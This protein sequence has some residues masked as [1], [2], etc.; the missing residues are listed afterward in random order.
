[1][2][3]FNQ[4]KTMA[5]P[6]FMSRQAPPNYVAG[7]GRGATGFTTRSDIGPARESVAGD[8]AAVP[9]V[10]TGAQAPK[11]DDDDERFQDPDNETG[12]FSSAPYEVD[13]E[14]AD[15]IYEAIDRKMDERR[16]ARREAREREEQEKYR[17][18]RPKI[19]Q[20][21]ADLKRGLSTITD[22]QW[23][24]IPE[25]GDLVRKRS[26]NANL[27]V[28]ERYMP[29]PDSVLLGAASS[30]YS[31][32]LSARDQ[33]L[34]GAAT[35]V[36]G[37]LT[38]FVQFGQARDKVLGLKLD[39]VS[40]SVS[41]QTTIDPKGYLT[42][43]NSVQVKSDAEISDIK[44]ARTLLR[45]VTTTNPKHGPGWI[46]AARLEEV[47]G[48]LAVAREIIAKGC[49]EC[50]K[51][52]D[53]WLEA[54][55]LNT[56]DNAKV[57]LANAVRSL[58]QS[59]KIWMRATQL[60]AEIKAKKRVLRR[61]LE[62]IP[63]SVSLWKATV[64]L[65]EDPEDARILL[66]QAVKDVPLAVELWLA[67]AKLET[68]DNARKVLNQ[69]RGQNP[70]SHE[71]WIT[72]AKLEEH[73][74]S[75]SSP[76]MIIGRAVKE[77]QQ[78]GADIDREV[79]IKEA[80]QCEKDASPH[81][82]Q[83][84]IKYTIEQ[85]VEPEDYKITFVEDAESCIAHGSIVTARAIFAHA[86]SLLPKDRSLWQKAAF[87]EKEHG[88]NESLE[89]L[90][91]RAVRYCPDAE[92]LWLMGAKQKWLMGDIDGARAVLQEAFAANPN[93]EQL[94]LAAVKLEAENE[95]Y[96]RARP[97]LAKARNEA[98]TVRVWMKS[99]VFERQLGQPDAAIKLLDEALVKFPSA[100][101]LWMMRGQVEEDENG[102]L[103]AAREFYAKGVKSCSKSIPLWILSSRLEEKAD[104][105]TRARALLE[106]ARLLNP[107]NDLLWAESIRVEQRG[108]NAAMSKALMAKALQEC[109]TSGLLWAEAIMAEPRPT[110]KSKST[111]A[112]KKCE[113]DPRVLVTIARLFWSERKLDK[114]RSWF[115]RAT[116]IDPD[117]G[118][119]WAWWYAFE[120]EQGSEDQRNDVVTKCEAA[121]PRHGELWT[122]FSKDRRNFKL[123]IGEIL[124][125]SGK[126]LKNS[127]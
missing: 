34:G 48:K 119:T 18:E 1:M 55:R 5:V 96:H 25:V 90:L 20:Q 49:E 53:V 77:L 114:A 78:K 74:G 36:D 29:V 19:Q 87:L 8:A 66:S 92:V 84:I 86:T 45:S 110:R 102:N 4:L 75:T 61:A 97:L 117:L 70:T 80:E 73:H 56:V 76:D 51:S 21:F 104:M 17:K 94:Y 57:I 126:S 115:Q 12:L 106:R 91:K 24:N 63:N 99:A 6:D 72:A 15:K 46:A 62:F 108:G 88:T 127:I 125:L 60:E 44:K 93:S 13:D 40:D 43:L 111:D 85:G 101:K 64:S 123:K 105:M 47:A 82:C 118:D 71:I 42:D 103:A 79:W 120:K 116:K 27:K 41:G 3:T 39:Q 7:L 9:G 65:E 32:T 112:L 50:P 83:A 16:R 23:A 113:N 31:N 98:G 69:A 33:V 122:R 58:P 52:E 22:D 2:A 124:V 10:A 35:P 28:Q 11:D 14:E 89:E 30:G 37:T 95:Q 81:V 121:E 67:L 54:A 26:K 59:V 109:P 68:H 100:A 38:D 107:A